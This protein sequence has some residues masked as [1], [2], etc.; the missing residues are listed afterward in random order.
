MM[1]FAVLFGL[2]MDYEVFLLTAFR[3]HW[4]ITGDMKIAV[5]RGLADSGRLVTA[6]AMIMVVVFASFILSDNATVKMF[7]VGLATAV[8]VDAT[9]VRC[10][11]VPAIMV[12]P[13]RE[14]G[15]CQVGLTAYSRNSMSRA[16]RTHLRTSRPTTRPAT[17]AA[18][19]SSF[20]ARSSLL[21]RLWAWSSRGRS[22][23]AYPLCRLTPAPRSR[24]RLF[25]V[26]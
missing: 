10:L 1:M 22:S 14:R 16:T 20:T 24:C 12:P 5:R 6:A 25:W 3:E 2:S 9:I 7:G 19:P 17:S 11:L 23:H 26:A 4:S 13:R 15:G 21:A 18:D 8:A